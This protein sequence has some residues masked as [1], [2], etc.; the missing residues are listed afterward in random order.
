VNI[1]LTVRA[2]PQHRLTAVLSA[3]QRRTHIRAVA[4]ITVASVA[5]SEL[6]TYVLVKVLIGG[7]VAQGMLIA[8]ICSAPISAWIAHRERGMRRLIADQRD[9][10][11]RLNADLNARNA[12]LDAFAR[13]VAHDLK[14]PLTTIIGLGEVLADNPVVSTNDEIRDFVS[15]I[16]QSGNR[17]AE[18][19][20]GLLL[21]HGI[22]HEDHEVTAVDSEATVDAALKALDSIVT[23]NQVIVTRSG[24]F[25]LVQANDSWLEQVW[26]NLIANAIKYGGSP[27]RVDLSAR[28]TFDGSI[29]FEVRDN[30]EGIATD[31]RTRVFDE[32]QR[33]EQS[34][35][36]GHGLGLAIVERVISRLGGAVGVDSAE[37]GGS[38]FWFTVPST[39]VQG[40]RVAGA[41]GIEPVTSAV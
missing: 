29:R 27:P 19:I 32:Y 4:L 12:A 34:D 13:S 6:I 36:D 5:A 3:P 24:I 7:F 25:P 37:D 22:Q 8:L 20:D 41:T 39:D 31:H 26:V 23:D 1:E 2:A 40:F 28:P 10:L 11:S 14:N 9:Q 15:L 16:V 38:V 30:G 17:S 21:L 18:I 35:I 33:A